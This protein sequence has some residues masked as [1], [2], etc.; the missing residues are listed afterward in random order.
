MTAEPVDKER[1]QH[2]SSF[3]AQMLKR[4]GLDRAWGIRE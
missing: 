1:V 4:A 3:L 2:S